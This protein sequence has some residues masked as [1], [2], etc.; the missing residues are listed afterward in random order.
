MGLD[1]MP[2]NSKEA[3]GR[4]TMKRSS[5]S[6]APSS[7]VSCRRHRLKNNNNNKPRQLLYSRRCRCPF[8]PLQFHILKHKHCFRRIQQVYSL[9]PP[10]PSIVDLD[11]AVQALDEDSSND[12]IEN[13]R[14]RLY[15]QQV[16]HF[17]SAVEK[18]VVFTDLHCAPSTL[19][20]SLQVLDTVHQ[21]AV[22]RG[23][24]NNNNNNV[25]VLFLGDFWHH[26]GTLRVDCLNAVLHALGNWTV[27]MV[28]IP[29]NHDQVTLGGHNHGL[30]PLENAYRV[31]VNE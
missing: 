3:A 20:T 17:R 28:L 7:V 12:R 14:D 26:R 15:L 13:K 18:W 19:E 27:P 30:T 9:Y 23:K 6:E 5:K 24:D 1:G 22:E 25:G 29:G 4:A 31:A 8:L 16:A 11:A 10:P 21:L 2:Y